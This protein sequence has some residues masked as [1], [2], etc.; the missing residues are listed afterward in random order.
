MGLFDRKSTSSTTQNTTNMQDDSLNGIGEG[1]LAASGNSQINQYVTSIDAGALQTATDAFKS[2]A[3]VLSKAIDSNGA[4]VK[5][6]LAMAGGLGEDAMGL[7][8]DLGLGA[9]KLSLD[10]Q[11]NQA[12][13]AADAMQR[14]NQGMSE[15]LSTAAAA[16]R[17]ALASNKATQDSAFAFT[18]KANDAVAKTAMDAVGM[19][20]HITSKNADLAQLAISQVKGAWAD[21]QQANANQAGGDYRMLMWALAAVVA[22]VAVKAFKGQ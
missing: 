7:A 9:F 5:L 14:V 15:A 22:M 2:S 20:E 1:A 19:S 6:S 16:G 3:D 8:K 12:A 11:K 4:G 21:A 13:V 10:S 17:E 18:A